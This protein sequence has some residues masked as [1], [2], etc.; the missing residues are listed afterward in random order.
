MINIG[1]LGIIIQKANI[2]KMDGTKSR[3]RIVMFPEYNIKAKIEN[4]LNDLS[5]IYGW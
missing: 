2:L 4:G 5:H 1:G 3:C